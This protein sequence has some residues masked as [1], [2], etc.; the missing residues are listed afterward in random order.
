M[1]LGDGQGPEAHLSRQPYFQQMPRFLVHETAIHFI[2]SFRFPL[3]EVGPTARLRR[4]VLRSSP[5]RMP[6]TSC[7]SSCQVRPR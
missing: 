6:A 1:R 3:G 2:D 4:L 5:A 7:S